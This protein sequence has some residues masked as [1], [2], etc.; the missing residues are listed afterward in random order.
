M[1]PIAVALCGKSPSMATSFLPAM[2]PEYEIT[3]VFHTPSAVKSELPSLIAN[4]PTKPS[5]GL[6]S[7]AENAISKPPRAIIVGAGFSRAELDDMK[8]CAGG[9]SVPWLYPDTLKMAAT[10]LHAMAEG[11][12]IGH[13]A[14]RAKTVLREKGLVEGSEGEGRGGEVWT[15]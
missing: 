7:N 4:L 8:T 12:V 15:F 11:G 5:S 6:G 2:Q 9:G 3:H 14:D 13:I 10:P 1:A